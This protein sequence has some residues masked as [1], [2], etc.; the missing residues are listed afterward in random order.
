[1]QRKGPKGGVQGRPSQALMS[2]CANKHSVTLSCAGI[3]AS[4]GISTRALDAQIAK[5]QSWQVQIAVQSQ[6]TR[7]GCGCFRGLFG[8]SRKKNSR[9]VP[10][11]TSESQNATNSR[12]WGTGKRKPFGNLRSTLPEPCPHLVCRLFLKSTVPA[13]SSF[14]DICAI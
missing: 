11:K 13:F 9:K 2:S 8:G 7:E 14:S 1:M 6:K 12:I 10:G 5:S 3:C 4:N